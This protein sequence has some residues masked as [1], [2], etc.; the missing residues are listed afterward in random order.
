MDPSAAAARDGGA[1]ARVG[2]GLR[3]GAAVVVGC[4]A[5]GAGHVVPPQRAVADVSAALEHPARHGVAAGEAPLVVLRRAH[6][7]GA[8][9]PAQ[10]AGGRRRGRGQRQEQ[11]QRE[12]EGSRCHGWRRRGME[13]CFPFCEGASALR[14]GKEWN[15]FSPLAVL[16]CA[17]VY[18]GERKGIE[19]LPR[20]LCGGCGAVRVS[21]PAQVRSRH[22]ARPLQM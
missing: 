20:P 6:H 12:Q 16:L 21:D 22:P 11:E 17:W 8:E 1:A 13:L 19:E 4:A 15:A 10:L 7:G 14:N 5:H 9:V 2:V 3:S 18:R